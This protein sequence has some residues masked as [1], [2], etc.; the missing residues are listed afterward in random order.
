MASLA[1]EAGVR[2]VEPDGPW[3]GV[4]LVVDALL[5]TG[6]RGEPRG[7]LAALLSRIADLEVP[8]VAVDGPS[9]LDL[10]F[11]VQRG[12]LHA[13]LTVT[14][15]GYRRGHLLA[16]DDVGDLV[17]VDIGFPGPDP[18]WPVFLTEA[19]AA[20]QVEPFPADAHKGTRGRVVV[21]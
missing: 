11:G 12:P 17:V 6:S 16:R 20:E 7:P 1:R 10:E 13:A 21:V 15:G 9:G 8:V 19:G 14:F 4:G 3:P 5:G 2:V 18:A